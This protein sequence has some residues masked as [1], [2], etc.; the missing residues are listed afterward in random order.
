MCVYV[1]VCVCV[2]ACAC[3]RAS[4][5]IA[6]VHGIFASRDQETTSVVVSQILSLFWG[7]REWR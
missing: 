4:V 1:C 3:T 7:V 5:K 2:C 6:C